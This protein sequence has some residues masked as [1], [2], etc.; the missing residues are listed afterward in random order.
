MLTGAPDLVPSGSGGQPV[1]KA[2]HESTSL[3]RPD[4]LKPQSTASVLL[5][6][7]VEKKPRHCLRKY[8]FAVPRRVFGVLPSAVIGAI[9]Q[10]G[11]AWR[12]HGPAGLLKLAIHNIAY[13][14]RSRAR[15]AV[16]PSLDEFDRKYGTQ[17]DGIREIRTLEAASLP[18]ARYAVRYGPSGEKGFRRSLLKLNIDPTRFTFIDFGSGKGRVLLIA[19]GFPFKAVLGIEF[20]QELHE[21]AVQNIARFPQNLITAG[22]LTSIREDASSFPLPPSDLVCYFHNPFGPPVL[23]EVVARLEAHCEI[24]YRVLVVYLDPQHRDIFEQTGKFA[25][26]DET[27]STLILTAA[28][29]GH[30]EAGFG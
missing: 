12:R 1:D 30:R 27:P 6:P 23:S 14:A 4:V 19:A 11:Y 7:M 25:V 22:T 2:S 15:A 21:I 24:G 16:S 17:T 9:P 10:F 18:N 8:R 26:L 13:C 29:A 28:R 3:Q 20:S 5:Y